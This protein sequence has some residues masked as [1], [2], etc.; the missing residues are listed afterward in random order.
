[1]I[2]PGVMMISANHVPGEAF[3]HLKDEPIEIGKDCWIGANACILPAV[4]LGAKIIVDV[5]SVLTN[6]FPTRSIILGNP[7]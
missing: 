4:N 5:V 1:M 2:A 3:K 7:A 6:F